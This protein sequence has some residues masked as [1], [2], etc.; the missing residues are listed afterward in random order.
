MF[1]KYI[2]EWKSGMVVDDNAESRID[3]D[4]L[5]LQ[6]EKSTEGLS[7]SVVQFMVQLTF[8][9]FCIWLAFNN[10]KPYLFSNNCQTLFV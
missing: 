10:V 3:P 1:T 4:F 5:A 8:I 6:N 2:A 7:E 9:S